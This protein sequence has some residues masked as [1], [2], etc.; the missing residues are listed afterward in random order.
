MM[1]TRTV[2]ERDVW[3]G[4]MM[5]CEVEGR[6]VLLVNAGGQIRAF[7]DRC[8]HQAVPL[9]QGRL[10]GDVLTCWAHE[11]QYD[12]CSGEGLNPLGVRLRR[13]PVEVRDGAVWVDVAGR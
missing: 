6:R 10:E 11:W 12:A 2:D 9:S 13:F 7:E 8:A 1:W 3:E 4:E 5:A